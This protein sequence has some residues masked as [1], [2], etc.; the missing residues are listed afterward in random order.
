MTSGEK[1]SIEILIDIKNL[2]N[3]ETPKESLTPN[4]ILICCILWYCRHSN[5]RLHVLTKYP[6]GISNRFLT[7]IN[8]QTINFIPKDGTKYFIVIMEIKTD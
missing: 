2:V 3:L 5:S 6:E 7:Y 4:F 8:K 1:K